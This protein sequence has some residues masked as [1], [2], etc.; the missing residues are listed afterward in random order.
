MRDR[1]LDYL[2]IHPAIHLSFHLFI[3]LSIY[4]NLSKS[5]YLSIYPSSHPSIYL[6]V[7][8]YKRELVPGEAIIGLGRFLGQGNFCLGGGRPACRLQAHPDC[9]AEVL[10]LRRVLGCQGVMQLHGSLNTP[11]HLVVILGFCEGGAV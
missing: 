4:I 7:I 8:L 1:Y 6:S 10:A 5:I 3:F 11:T 2:S 9:V